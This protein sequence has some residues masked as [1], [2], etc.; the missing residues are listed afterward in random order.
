M[1]STMA[2]PTM[3][4]TPRG[5]PT[6][7]SRSWHYPNRRLRKTHGG[8]D[9]TFLG[10]SAPSPMV[11]IRIWAVILARVGFSRGTVFHPEGLGHDRLDLIQLPWLEG[12]QLLS[13][14]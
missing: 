11:L 6:S 13:V 4:K 1:A 3:R 7:P 2:A 9:Q 8:G 14:L 5:G 10:P 12:N